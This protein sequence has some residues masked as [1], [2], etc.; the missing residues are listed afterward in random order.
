MTY[1]KR[2]LKVVTECNDENNT[3]TC[4]AIEVNYSDE[5][6]GFIWIT[7]YGE[8]EYKVENSDGYDISGKTYKTLAGAKREAEGIAWRREETGYGYEH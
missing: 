7:K 2:Q 8:K 6:R 3:P 1:P 4:W 5:V